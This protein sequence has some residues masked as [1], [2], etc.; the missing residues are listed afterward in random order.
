MLGGRAST[1]LAE[2]SVS[3]LPFGNS[4]GRRVFSLVLFHA[5][6][7]ACVAVPK[8]PLKNS[9]KL[10]DFRRHVYQS[11]IDSARARNKWFPNF[12]QF[13]ATTNNTM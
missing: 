8:P 1:S 3:P 4:I 12:K 5:L 13:L 7:L 11:V 2:S 9:R 6:D 10:F